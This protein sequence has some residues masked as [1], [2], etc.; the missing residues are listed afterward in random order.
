MSITNAQI[1]FET[2][3][4]GGVSKVDARQFILDQTGDDPVTLDG[5][6]VVVEIA[7]TVELGPDD[8]NGVTEND[9]DEIAA[10]AQDYINGM[11]PGA[12]FDFLR[13]SVRDLST[14]Y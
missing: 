10:I 9:E 3:V 11:I 13:C 1:M 7:V 14:S 12:D 5:A 2:L 8:L 6:T 4:D